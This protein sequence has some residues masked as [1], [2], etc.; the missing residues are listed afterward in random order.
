MKRH[1]FKSALLT[2]LFSFT[3][4][5]KGYST[6]YESQVGAREFPKGNAAVALITL[7]SAFITQAALSYLKNLSI[8]IDVAIMHYETLGHP[9]FISMILKIRV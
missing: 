8:R 9:P 4:L 6:G 2:L 5:L 3:T 1:K 7:F